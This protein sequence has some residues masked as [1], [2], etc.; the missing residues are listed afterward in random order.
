VGIEA[1]LHHVP[2]VLCG[3]S[4]FHH[5]AT[6]VFDAAQMDDAIAHSIAAPW[7]HDAFLY[8]YFDQQC[9]NAGKPTLVT[10]FLAKARSSAR[11]HSG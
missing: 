10:D 9:L 11:L 2:A 6:T 8:W 1:H 3:Q 4:D 7:P 5:A